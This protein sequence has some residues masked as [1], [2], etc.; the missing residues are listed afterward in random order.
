[1]PAIMPD[2]SMSVSIATEEG[3]ARRGAQAIQL[4]LETPAGRVHLLRQH[5]DRVRA[6]VSSSQH[7]AA[8]ADGSDPVRDPRGGARSTLGGLH[9]RGVLLF[10]RQG[11]MVHVGDPVSGRSAR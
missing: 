8:V 3:A 6:Q 1:M 11:R 9:V 10:R 4:A 7:L 5:R 2:A